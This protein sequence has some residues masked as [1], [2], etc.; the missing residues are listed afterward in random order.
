MAWNGKAC[1]EDASATIGS[2]LSRI[3]RSGLFPCSVFYFGPARLTARRRTTDADQVTPEVCLCAARRAQVNAHFVISLVQEPDLGRKCRL[4]Q[5]PSSQI[6]T[7]VMVKPSVK[8]VVAPASV[9]R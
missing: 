3:M 4:V 1:S 6:G 5:S 8:S 2:C 9:T 7:P